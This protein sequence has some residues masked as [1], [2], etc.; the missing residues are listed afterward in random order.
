MGPATDKHQTATNPSIKALPYVFVLLCT[1]LC[2][3]SNFA[4]IFTMLWVQ[5]SA[6]CDCGISRSLKPDYQSDSTRTSCRKFGYFITLILLGF[7]L[8]VKAATL[9]FIFGLGSAISS[10]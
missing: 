5:W 3:L 1:I 9:I 7:S 2:A 6:V 4:T 8:T 10:T